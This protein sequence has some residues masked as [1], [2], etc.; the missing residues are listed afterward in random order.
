LLPF[1]NALSGL[2]TWG[3]T[4]IDGLFKN[5][6]QPEFNPDKGD[7]APPIYGG[8]AVEKQK[9]RLVVIGSISFMSN[10]IVRMPDPILLRR[11]ILA[12]RFP[13]N[14]EFATNSI[15]WAA[16][17]DPMIAISPSAMD[18]SRVGN[19]GTGWGKFFRVG[20]FLAILPILVIATGLSVYAS[21]KD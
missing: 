2:K 6:Q 8:A 11:G 1:S 21:R 15:F 13:G 5:T 3:E 18:V 14:M 9:G 19:V 7:L 10:N 12:W 16:H 4:D 20:I 17:L